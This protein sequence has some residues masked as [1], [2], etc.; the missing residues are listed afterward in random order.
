M[1]VDSTFG[2]SS[3]GEGFRVVSLRRQRS[4]EDGVRATW[5]RIVGWLEAEAP[6]CHAAVR[7]PE[8]P[9]VVTDALAN[10]GVSFPEYVSEWWSLHDGVPR[11]HGVEIFPGAFWPL[12]IR[13]MIESRQGRVVHVEDPSRLEIQARSESL[14]AG[15]HAWYFP[16]SFIPLAQD[17]TGCVLSLDLRAGEK[18]GCLKVWDRDEGA[19]LPPIAPGLAQYLQEILDLLE[20]RTAGQWVPVFGD[21]WLTWTFDPTRRP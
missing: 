21:G 17:P 2:S 12:G 14:P 3:T 19:L 11:T 5:T 4:M 1:P 20:G 13:E 9:A 16:R 7:G 10:L 15:D 18:H 8:S 6:L